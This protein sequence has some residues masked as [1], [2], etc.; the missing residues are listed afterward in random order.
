MQTSSNFSQEAVYIH[1]HSE[2][3]NMRML[4]SIIKIETLVDN[5]INLGLKGIGITD[6]ESLSGHVRLMK[7]VENGKKKGTIPQEFK[8]IY[9]NEIYLVDGL[10]EPD[11]TGKRV[12]TSPFYHFI[13]LAKDEVGHKQ[14]RQL[15]SLAWEASYYTGKMERV[16]TT[17]DNLYKIVSQNKGHLIASTACIGGELGKRILNGD[18]ENDI[19]EF[20]DFCKEL[21]G[22]DFYLEMQ[23][24][25]NPEQIY[26]N[27]TII[28]LSEKYN[29]PYV[30]TTDTH[31][32]NK[33]DREVHEAYLNS[34]ED[35][36]R[37]LDEFYATTY[38]MSQEEIHNFLDRQIGSEC[39]AKAFKNS[40]L[41]ADKVEEYS[42]FCPTIVP[43][44][45]VPDF[46]VDHL[47]G[48]Y[49][50]NH[51]YIQK[52]A[53]SD[54]QYDRYL[55]KLV[56]D[57]F[58]EKIPFTT[59]SS[60]K[61]FEYVDRIETELKEMW[62]VTEK[63]GTSI[64]SYYLTTLELIEIM[65][66]EGDSLV[67]IARGS[68]TGMETM[69]LIGLT[70][71]DPIP[72]GLPCWRHIT[73]EKIELS[74]V[75]IDSQQS[76][77]EQIIQ[78]VKKRKGHDRVLNCCT[79][80]TEGSKS[81]ILTAGKGLGL[82]ADIKSYIAN[83]IPVTRGETWSL[84]DCVYGNEKEGRK[85]I[86][87][88]INECE[89]Y[90]KLLEIALTIEGLVCGRSMHASAVY[91]FNDS[92]IEHNAMM[93]TPKGV[94][95][96]Q[97]N[98]KDSDYCSGLKMDFLTIQALDRIRI[99]MELLMKAGYMEWQGSLRATYDKYLHP[100]VLDYDTKEM[101]NMVADNAVINL[102]QFDT[103]VGLQAAKKMKPQ[104]LQ[105]LAA[106][107]SI[108]RLMVSEEGAEQPIDTFVRYKNDIQEWYKCMREE[109]HL[110]ED[111][112]QLL[113]K[114]LLLTNGIGATQEDV[115]EL[116]MDNKIAGFNVTQSNKLRK[117]I[118]KKDK[119]L[120]QD[121][122]DMFFKHGKE[123]GTSEN[124]LNYIWKE[125]VGK[126][127][128][129]SFSKNHT[130]PYSAIGLQEL[131]L[132]YHYPIIY[133]NTASLIV[134]AGA[135][136]DSEN[137]QSTDYGKI[138]TAIADMK[139][140]GIKVALPVINRAKF[141]FIPDEDHGEIIYSL[142]ALCGIGDAVCD[143]I[144]KNQPYDS[145]ED[146]CVRLVDTKLI[147]DGQM[148]VLIKAGCFTELDDENRE[149]TMKKY[150][151]RNMFTACEKLGMQQFNRLVELNIIP[152][153]LH[154]LVRIKNFKAYILQDK[155]LVKHIIH[156]N[157][158]IPKA[159][160]HD[161][162][163]K[164]DSISQPFFVEHFSQDSVIGVVG[165][166]FVISEKTFKKEWESKMQPLRDWMAQ[167]DILE[168]Y[169]E[170]LFNTLYNE[171][172][173][174]SI[175]KWEMDSLSFYHGQHELENIDEKYYNVVN[176]FEQPE[177]PIAYDSYKRT[178]NGQEVEFPKYNIVRLAGTV[179]DKNNDRHAVTL[180]TK[181]GVVSLKFNKGQY[182]FY[183]KRI[184]E[185][186]AIVDESWFK[187][188]TKILVCGYR[189]DDVFRVCKYTDSIYKHSCM[190]IE[191]VTENDDLIITTD[192]KR[193]ESE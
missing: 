31:Y 160:Y 180:L 72:W 108:M 77:R 11:D 64:S 33:E 152:N 173:S 5:A 101:W 88:F 122:K 153:H 100:D 166:Y 111:E 17:K 133:W 128:G 46:K 22:D 42:L 78:A 85:P 145:F 151:K 37:E 50:D 95:V 92:Y 114:Y 112:V 54:N 121:M 7:Y 146:F 90:G 53:Y 35:E 96:T 137:N 86:K 119:K 45:D 20:I 71:I 184:S 14:L 113:E 183:Q 168:L 147:K 176:F 129:Y 178:I 131:N 10:T 69:Y 32:L 117:G 156:D 52:F 182:G 139:A 8:V 130:L 124:M 24:S 150:I 6:H 29:I 9:G 91:L 148:I 118:S 44:A 74:D 98:M 110:T 144:I 170:A 38:M 175:S 127:L 163:F 188:G 167:K 39:V 162:A 4:D 83:M 67:G 63:L 177:Q 126:Q 26:V 179:L 142:K 68:V 61:F 79:F 13:L 169:N 66:N 186:G 28:Q 138:A 48:K 104:N 23:P 115:M 70:Q 76:K 2:F 40:L 55:L 94:E 154:I 161:R 15:S 193:V 27:E 19:L 21:F 12:A 158:K 3:S 18:S 1:N 191:E 143:L 43:A 73:H 62:L 174:G 87:E 106:A 81:A 172:A 30:I 189:L 140:R 192:R 107:N 41:L 103:Q 99:C 80:R 136:E 84:S 36:E 58:Y 25:N 120:Q 75:D 132:A 134:N 57:G 56:E 181:Y 102:F 97:F 93:R 187:R 49:Y 34:K 159:G 165:E 171:K 164:L 60:D 155:F 65:W 16:P 82:G 157:K 123:I 51:E 109:Y 125:V 141:G 149:V 190:K 185:N 105:E 47:F 89:K 116:S 59:F 135:D